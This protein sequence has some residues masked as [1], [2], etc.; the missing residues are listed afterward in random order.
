M[1]GHDLLAREALPPP[2]PPPRPPNPWEVLGLAFAVI[3]LAALI[4]LL[5][6]GSVYFVV[7][8]SRCHSDGDEEAVKTV[9]VEQQLAELPPA[10]HHDPQLTSGLILTVSNYGVCHSVR[11]TW[12][13]HVL[14]SG[15]ERDNPYHGSHVT[16]AGSYFGLVVTMDVYGYNLIHGQ[17]STTTITVGNLEGDFKSNE[18]AIWV[19]WQVYPNH[20][21]DSRTR[22]FTL[23]TRDAYRTTGCFD[24]E[25]PDFEPTRGEGLKPGAVIDPLSHHKITIKVLQDRRTRDWWI[26]A[27]FNGSTPVIGRYPAKLFD[28]LYRKAIHIGMGGVVGAVGSTPTPPMGSGYFPSH[29]SATITDISYIG[30]NGK[31]T[32]FSLNTRK[33]ETKSSCYSVSPITNARFSYGG[34][35][36]CSAHA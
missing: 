35:G 23:W 11:M 5:I 21:G 22:F 26:H 15:Y 18:D 28:S 24:M 19:G 17:V 13:E 29:K 36:G 2:P 16:N 4:V 1:A 33:V 8:I 6:L 9:A 20:Y 32:P 27:G 12:Y 3:G 7:W 34:P 25:C 10:P 30:E 14:G 31:L